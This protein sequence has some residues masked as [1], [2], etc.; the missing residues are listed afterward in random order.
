M[1]VFKQKNNDLMIKIMANKKG[2]IRN[3]NVSR[4]GLDS[5]LM[6]F[7][8][9]CIKTIAIKSLEIYMGVYLFNFALF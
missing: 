1:T 9:L 5:V 8:P 7:C 3:I 2:S 4:L 6:L